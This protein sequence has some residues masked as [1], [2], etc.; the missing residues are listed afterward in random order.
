[1]HHACRVDN[2]KPTLVQQCKL[3]GACPGG[4]QY[5]VGTDKWRDVGGDALSGGVPEQACW[6]LDNQTLRFTECSGDKC[7]VECTA[8]G[9]GCADFNAPLKPNPCFTG[10]Q[11]IIREKS[12]AYNLKQ[13]IEN[14]TMIRCRDQVGNRCCPGNRGDGCESCCMEENLAT[15][16]TPSCNSRQWH[17]VDTS[18][19]GSC[20]ICPEQK[21]DAVLFIV[22]GFLILLF[23]P[24]IA[25]LS[26]LAKHAGAAQGPVLSIMNFF[27]A[28]DLFQ[29]LDLNWPIEFRTFCRTVAS[30]FS[31]NISDLLKKFNAFISKFITLHLPKWLH[32]LIPNF[33][34]PPP[35]CALHLSYE[36]KWM[37]S[38]A[39][40]LFVV[41]T[42][43]TLV[44]FQTI[45][46][47]A[48][49]Q[50]I[51]CFPKSASRLKARTCC[52]CCKKQDDSDG[53]D[54]DDARTKLDSLAVI[55]DDD[56]EAEPS[57]EPEAEQGDSPRQR[58]CAGQRWEKISSDFRNFLRR[59]SRAVLI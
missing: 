1:M 50:L 45:A 42:M 18:E 49:K 15:S 31:F 52:C 2:Y 56:P 46:G 5:G 25:K 8:N 44:I 57:I 43:V 16:L 10:T 21:L 3:L 47:A 13:G 7:T 34:L 53:S 19:G 33:A 39:S 51:K 41:L 12:G 58:R 35:A 23:A 37:L 54:S 24:I 4:M 30:L 32:D 28:S 26:E 14:G 40:P 36:K 11:Y 55:L 59:I 9:G 29:G 6:D 20:H 48:A 38:M 17:S 22:V 27:Q